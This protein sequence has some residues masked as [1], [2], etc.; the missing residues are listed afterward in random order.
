MWNWDADTKVIRDRWL[1]QIPHPL[2]LLHWHPNITSMRFQPGEGSPWLWNFN[3]RKGSF[4]ALSAGR[5]WCGTSRAAPS[6]SPCPAPGGRPPSPSRGRPRPYPPGGNLLRSSKNIC[7]WGEK[8]LTKIVLKLFQVCY[9]LRF[10]N[11]KDLK[12]GCK[13]NSLLMWHILW[14]FSNFCL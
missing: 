8:Y 5:L 12:F 14:Y 13:R 7:I 1:N 4:P 2:G 10:D 6:P 9:L 3:L 11:D